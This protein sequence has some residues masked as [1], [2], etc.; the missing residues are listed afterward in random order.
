MEEL[1]KKGLEKLMDKA[2]EFVDVIIKPPLQEVGGIL[3]DQVR[4]WRYKNQINIL[5]KAKEYHEKK[6]I[7]PKKIPVK[8]LFNLLEASSY[9]E[10]EN[11]KTK[12]AALLG[13]ASDSKNKFE[14]HSIFID[15]LKQLTPKEADVL[16]FMWAEGVSHNGR[17]HK[18]RYHSNIMQYEMLVKDRKGENINFDNYDRKT[19]KIVLNNLIRLNLVEYLTPKIENENDRYSLDRGPNYVIKEKEQIQFTELGFKFMEECNYA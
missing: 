1:E 5:L 19:E 9:E 13:N 15:I 17:R 2:F 3:T 6:G 7:S 4:F 12:W 18:R 11:L 14:L 8:T 16:D 10:D